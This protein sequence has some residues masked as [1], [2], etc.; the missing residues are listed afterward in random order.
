M[1]QEAHLPC[2]SACPLET[3]IGGK[4]T[5][6]VLYKSSETRMFPHALGYGGYCCDFVFFYDWIVLSCCLHTWMT[7]ILLLKG[8]AYYCYKNKI[9]KNK[10]MAIPYI[11]QR[12]NYHI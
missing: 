3:E 4:I 9:K 1:T 6:L 5:L 2:P 8:I 10:K 11:L 7:G 12:F